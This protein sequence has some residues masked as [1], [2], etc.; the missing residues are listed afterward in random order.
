MQVLCGEDGCEVGGSEFQQG[1]ADVIKYGSG[2]LGPH[3]PSWQLAIVLAFRRRRLR[4]AC[5][6][7]YTSPV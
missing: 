4:R 5:T 1:R 6:T 3:H 2:G 7:S